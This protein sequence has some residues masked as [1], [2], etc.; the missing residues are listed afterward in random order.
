MEQDFSVLEDKVYHKKQMSENHLHYRLY[1]PQSLVQEILKE[2]YENPLCGHAGIFK[3]DKRLYDVAYWPGMWVDVKTYIK[4]CHV[5]QSLKADNRKPA[6]KI[7]QTTV[8]GPNEMLGIDIMGPLP[9]SPE[10]HEY[11][12]VVVDYFTRWVE[13]SSLRSATAKTV[14]RFLRKDIF[15]RW[16]TPDYILSDRG[17]QFVSSVFNELCDQWT[18]KHKLTTDKTQTVA[19]LHC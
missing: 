14:A 9:R 13:F 2:Y 6:G 19:E 12:V 18:V 16:G 17:P 7:Q 15:T 8:K 3:T 10:R 5:C 11:L 1:I 4:N